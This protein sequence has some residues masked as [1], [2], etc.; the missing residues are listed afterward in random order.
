[1]KTVFDEGFRRFGKV[2][3]ELDISELVSV[4]RLETPKPAFGTVY[5]PFHAALERL[6]IF[7]YLRDHIYGGMPIQL[8]YCNGYN[9]KLN[10]LEYHRGPEL[11][12]PADEIVL[13][14]ASL[15]EITGGVLDTSGVELILVP[16]QTPVLL[17]ET[18][19]HYA[20]AH[21]DHSFQVACALPRDTNASGPGISPQTD[22]DKKLAAR[23]KWLLAHADSAEAKVGAAVCLIGK[24]ID[25][26]DLEE[27][28][29]NHK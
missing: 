19:L 12:I 28:I 9:T 8:G 23:N 6:P 20:P 13:M 10:C 1:M 7:P 25:L 3:D 2:I 18:T 16:A 27:E 5:A 11:L 29:C 15:Q 22:E 24:N 26:S 4:L 14:L 17:Y 21:K